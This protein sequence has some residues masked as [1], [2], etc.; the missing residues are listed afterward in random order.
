MSLRAWTSTWVPVILLIPSQST[1]L[2]WACLRL[3]APEQA[4]CSFLLMHFSLVIVLKSFNLYHIYLLTYV[5][6]AGYVPDI[7]LG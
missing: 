1:L 5:Y 2:L 6:Q 3:P 7:V 4:S